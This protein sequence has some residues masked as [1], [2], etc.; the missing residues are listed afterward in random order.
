LDGNI[1]ASRLTAVR[2]DGV[3]EF[4]GF[5]IDRRVPMTPGRFEFF[6]RASPTGLIPFGYETQRDHIWPV[7]V[8]S[9]GIPNRAIEHD[10][11]YLN[12]AKKLTT[13]RLTR[14]Y[15]TYAYTVA[16]D[17]KKKILIKKF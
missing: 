14:V 10:W 17:P 15:F 2:A 6:H 3:I 16:V 9:A 4:V 12:T 7:G 11:A 1:A 5:P 13:R 8:F